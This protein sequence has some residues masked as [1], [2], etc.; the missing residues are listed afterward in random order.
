MPASRTWRKTVRKELMMVVAFTICSNNYL[1]HA[2]TLG[3]SFLRHH[4]NV[5]F[6]I[7]L[8]DRLHPDFDYSDFFRFT[9]IPVEELHIP[10]FEEMKAKFNIIELNT[11]VKPD[12]FLH[13]FNR[14]HADKVLYIDPDI[15]VASRFDEA[16][17]LLDDANIIITP[18]LLTPVDDGKV[19][20]DYH[21]LAGGVYNLGFIALSHYD[22]IRDFLFWWRQRVIQYGFGKKNLNMFYD[23]LWINYVPC[24]CD[25]YFILKHPGYNMA[26][27]NLHERKLI[28]DGDSGYRV[29]SEYPLRFFHFSGYKHDKPDVIC[30]YGT[31][32]NFSSRPDL[33]PLFDHYTS[34]LMSNKIEEIR[35]LPV[36]YY[37]DLSKPKIVN[38]PTLL[39]R[40]ALRLHIIKRAIIHGHL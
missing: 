2:K 16:L 7:G 38:T 39:E 36:F 13:I 29:N 22:K 10:E 27:W 15:W 21:T 26:H 5:T 19:P 20:S 14:F 40:I 3:D 33:K 11:A 35:A 31:R 23:Q 18:H 28:P 17:K 30:Y 1:A 4:P 34:L 25:N 12:Y 8:V 6:I 37:P 32:S 24:L 9:L